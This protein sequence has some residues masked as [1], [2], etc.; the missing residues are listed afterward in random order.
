M[1]VIMNIPNNNPPQLTSDFSKGNLLFFF[2]TLIST[3][4]FSKFRR[5]LPQQGS[6][7]SAHG[8]GAA[9]AQ[10]HQK[11]QE[12]LDFGRTNQSLSEMEEKESA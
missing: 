9:Q 4:R 7:P 5:L 3:F 2:K 8:Q 11:G 12:K 1:K 10:L 6:G